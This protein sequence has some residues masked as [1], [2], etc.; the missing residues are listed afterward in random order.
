MTEPSEAARIEARARRA[1]AAQL[2]AYNAGD[3]DAFAACFA[4]D[5]VLL[6]LKSGEERGRGRDELHAT[7]GALFERAP[8]L[9]ARVTDRSVVGN[10]VFDREVVTGRGSA[11]LHAMAIYEVAE[12]GLIAR[13]WFVME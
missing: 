8:E 12:D 6:D 2:T 11:P 5:V 7:Y 13:V 3:V 4:E 1:A 10:V 9:C